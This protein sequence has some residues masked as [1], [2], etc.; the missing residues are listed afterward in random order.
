MLIFEFFEKLL[1]GPSLIGGGEHGFECDLRSA[2]ASVQSE[3]F[4]EFILVHAAENHHG[5]S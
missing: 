5:L 3:K 4:S 2:E 1:S